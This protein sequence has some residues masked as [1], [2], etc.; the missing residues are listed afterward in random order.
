M[1][2]S[3][4]SLFVQEFDGTPRTGEIADGGVPLPDGLARDT[5]ELVLR[6]GAGRPYN[7]QFRVMGRWPSGN[8]Q[9][10]HVQ[11]PVT[12]AACG[13]LDLRLAVDGC[14]DPPESRVSVEPRPDEVVLQN[15]YLRILLPTERFRFPGEVVCDPS[16]Q[17]EV[18]KGHAIVRD[19]HL[20]MDGEDGIPF[21]WGADE[22]VEISVEEDGPLRAVVRLARKRR[23]PYEPGEFD[24]AVRVYLEAVRP[25]LKLEITYINTDPDGEI[26]RVE[27]QKQIRLGLRRLPGNSH[28]PTHGIRAIGRLGYSVSVIGIGEG[29]TFGGGR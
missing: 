24:V 17:G 4:Q 10:V 21:P 18:E 19:G 9:W 5:E 29:L 1:G 28:R 25:A 23:P 15:E 12:V 22:P 16:G 14:V 20:L 3:S 7:A 27:E 26:E 8:I 6:D 2:N 11:T 13:R